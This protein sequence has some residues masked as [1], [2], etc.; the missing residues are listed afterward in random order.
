MSAQAPAVEV[1]SS[2]GWP[3]QL[4]PAL[5]RLLAAGFTQEKDHGATDGRHDDD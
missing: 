4:P 5:A 3:A 1:D 2:V